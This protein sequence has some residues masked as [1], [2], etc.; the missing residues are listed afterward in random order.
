MKYG[1]LY[2]VEFISHLRNFLFPWHYEW[3]L[4]FFNQWKHYYYLTL[5]NSIYCLF[6]HRYNQGQDKLLSVSYNYEFP[7]CNTA[8]KSCMC[9]NSLVTLHSKLILYKSKLCQSSVANKNNFITYILLLI[10]YFHFKL[11]S[12]MWMFSWAI[13]HKKENGH[14]FCFH[15]NQNAN[16]LINDFLIKVISKKCHDYSCFIFL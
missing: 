10:K 5:A 14:H 4:Y 9:F 13:R 1:I 15:A 6:C 7:C 8:I 3:I 11:M 16:I 12:E 2:K